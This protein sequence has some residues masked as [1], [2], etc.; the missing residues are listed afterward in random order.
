MKAHT[1]L[2]GLGMQALLSCASHASPDR[3]EYSSTELGLAYYYPEGKLLLQRYSPNK[4]FAQ[5]QVVERNLQP[6]DL[7]GMG[8]TAMMVVLQVCPAW[9][10]AKQSGMVAARILDLPQRSNTLDFE[11]VIEID[12]K[13]MKPADKRPDGYERQEVYDFSNLE[14]QLILKDWCENP[15]KLNR[16]W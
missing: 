3:V 12:S 7:D 5:F 4:Y 2:V 10:L 16:R 13:K 6:S 9:R 1:F 14:L 8:A 11:F 15:A